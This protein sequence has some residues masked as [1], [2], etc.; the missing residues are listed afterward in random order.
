MVNVVC[1]EQPPASWEKRSM[2]HYAGLDV[3]VK[4]TSICII[5]EAGALCREVKVA[6]HPEDFALLL[7]TR[8]G[9][10]SVSALRLGLYHNGYTV[11]WRK[12]AF[13]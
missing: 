1:V 11:G 10:S 2:K 3:S 6:S 12:Q 13:P 8:P 4:E 9:I 5:D 7:P